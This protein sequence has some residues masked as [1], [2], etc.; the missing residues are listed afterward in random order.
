MLIPLFAAASLLS[1]ANSGGTEP[2]RPNII[3]MLTDDQ[4]A[5]AAGFAGNEVI[6]TPNLDRL[7]REGIYFKNAFVTTSICAMSRASILTGQ[8]AR[9]HGIWD[10]GESLTEQQL[11]DSYPARLKE[12]GYITGFIGKFGVGSITEKQARNYFDYWAGF[13]GQGSYNATYNGESMH[14]TQKIGAQAIDFLEQQRGI[15]RPFNLS[16]SF[17]A[18]HVEGDPGHFLPDTAYRSLY[19]NDS[20][21]PPA[22]AGD[23]YMNYFPAR[24]IKN[25]NGALNVARSRWH[26]RFD[27][28]EKY[29]ENV[30]KYYRL[31]H[32]V[33]VVLGRIR[34]KL[35]ELEFDKNTV[36]IFSSDNGFYLGEYGFAGK[37]YGSDP[38]IRVPMILYDPRTESPEATALDDMVLN[39]DIAPTILSIAGTE[40]PAGMQ[41]ADMTRLLIDDS[42]SWRTEFLYEHLWKSSDRYYIPSTEGLVTQDY[43]YMKYFPNRE[44]DNVIFEELYDRNMDIHETKNRIEEVEFKNIETQM[45]QKLEVLKKAAE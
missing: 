32:G 14:L 26:D 5:D 17:K 19:E 31:V 33:D 45:K 6:Q 18:P 35:K 39:I 23:S 25:E 2:D 30:K 4:R 8:Y 34:D 29:Q 13:N 1:C 21:A 37:W 16:I 27:T 11:A 24:F 36:I 15:D 7:A 43:K 38:S 9:R 41:G 40:V 12:A 44:I 42:Q 10:F 22:A 20:V 3:F 28:P